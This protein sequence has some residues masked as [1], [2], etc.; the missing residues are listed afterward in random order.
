MKKVIIIAALILI[1]TTVACTIDKVNKEDPSAKKELE[2][3]NEKY[4]IEDKTEIC[5]E[6]LEEIYRSEDNVYYLSCLKSDTIFIIDK[7]TKEEITLKKAMQK[8]ILTISE[9]QKTSITIYEAK[10][11]KEEE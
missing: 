2:S 5:A 7:E 10:I 8:K 9:L 4:Y 6:M 3:L 1:G 11:I